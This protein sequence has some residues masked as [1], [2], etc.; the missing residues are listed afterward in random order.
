MSSATKRSFITGRRTK[1]QFSGHCSDWIYTESGIPQGS[2]LLPIL[3]LFYVSEL[4]DSLH[5]LDEG[6]MAFGCLRWGLQIA[7]ATRKGEASFLA[8]SKITS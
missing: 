4:L 6:Y 8:L 5:Q 1:I 2:P 3:F 7:E